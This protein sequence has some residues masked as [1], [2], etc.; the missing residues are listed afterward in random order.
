MAV[1]SGR[2]SKGR[3]RTLRRISSSDGVSVALHQLGGGPSSPPVLVSHATGFHARCYQPV[4]DRLAASHHVVGLDYR[5][6][7]A[8][9]APSSWRDGP[10]DWRG[11]GDDAIAVAEHVAPDGGLIGVGHSMGGAALLMAAHRS[12]GLFRH[13]V[14]FEPIASS[15]QPPD[16][17]PLDMDQLPIVQGARRRRRRFDSF[18]DAYDNFRSKPPLSLMVP[19]ALRNYVDHG[20]HEVTLDDGSTVVELSCAP[21][22]EAGIFV[23]GRTNGVWDL[24]HEI[25]TPCTVIGG[26][27]EQ[28]QPSSGTEAIAAELRDGTYVLL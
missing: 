11:F 18:D 7:G 5:G 4:A 15:P 28:M 14:L 2:A 20:F 22:T 13:L 12:P 27:V 23:G 17:P 8:T 19:E 10:I 16:A 3:E 26:H 6:H 25:R 9:P 24:L 1:A 21:Q